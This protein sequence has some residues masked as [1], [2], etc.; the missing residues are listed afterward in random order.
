MVPLLQSASQSIFPDGREYSHS[1]C[2]AL[3][4]ANALLFQENAKSWAVNSMSVRFVCQV[5]SS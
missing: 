5:A 1:Y 3:R 2:A 4:L